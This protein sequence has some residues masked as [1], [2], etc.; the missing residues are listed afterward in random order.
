[1]TYEPRIFMRH[2]R[3]FNLC[4]IGVERQAE[5]L[6]IT[7]L[8]F[9]RDGYPCALAEK[10]SNPFMRKAAALARAEWEAAHGKGE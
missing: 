1:M 3:A 5:R 6:G 7:M 2:A 8:D 9:L 4:S 10:S